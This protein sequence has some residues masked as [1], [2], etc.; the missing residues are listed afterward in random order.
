MSE[1]KECDTCS[2]AVDFGYCRGCWVDYDSVWQEEIAELKKNL[3]AAIE[4]I[5]FYG[6]RFNYTENL[7]QGLS[8]V[9]CDKGKKAREWLAGHRKNH[10]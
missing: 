5:E 1:C 7:S 9:N 8:Q 10:E 4:V 2:N 6:G 3:E